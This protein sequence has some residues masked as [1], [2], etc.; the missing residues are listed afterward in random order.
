MGRRV[1]ETVDLLLLREE[2]DEGVP[3]RV[4]ECERP[5]HPRRRHVADRDIYVLAS[6]SL[7]HLRHHVRRDVDTAHSNA[8]LVERRCDATGPDAELERWPNVRESGEKL[9]GSSNDVRSV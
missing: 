6:G 8:E 4:D 7:A 1:S 2:D 5:I 3:D 9:H